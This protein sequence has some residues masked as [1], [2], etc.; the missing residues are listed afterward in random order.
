VSYTLDYDEPIPS[1]VMRLD[2]EHKELDPMLDQVQRA[3]RMGSCMRPWS[4]FVW[5]ARGC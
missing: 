3:V 4:S 5:S 2:A 1:V